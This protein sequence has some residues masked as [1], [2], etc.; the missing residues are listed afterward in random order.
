MNLHHP[1]KIY[2]N[3]YDHEEVQIKTQDLVSGVQVT[4]LLAQWTY[5]LHV[6]SLLLL[7]EFLEDIKGCSLVFF[8]ATKCFIVD[9]TTPWL[10]VNAFNVWGWLI[11][12]LLGTYT[13]KQFGYVTLFSLTIIMP[14]GT[15]GPSKV[16]ALPLGIAGRM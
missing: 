12:L 14:L 16:R 10:I 2:E 5:C 4:Y 1:M 9:I 7:F 6:L 3:I 15:I 8:L 11:G 13:K